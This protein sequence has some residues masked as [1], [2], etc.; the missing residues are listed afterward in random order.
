MMLFLLRRTSGIIGAKRQMESLCLC[1]ILLG[2]VSK[3]KIKSFRDMC[4]WKSLL[5]MEK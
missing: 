2:R 1:V 3:V 5:K 4:L